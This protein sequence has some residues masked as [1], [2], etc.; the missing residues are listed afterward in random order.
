MPGGLPAVVGESLQAAA[1]GVAAA[2][3]GVAAA[4]AAIRS[5][6]FGRGGGR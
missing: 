1:D 2:F 6:E 5:V 4:D 3:R